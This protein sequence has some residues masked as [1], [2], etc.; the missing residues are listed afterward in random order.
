MI[1]RAQRYLCDED[2]IVTLRKYSL[3]IFESFLI[4]LY[5]LDLYQ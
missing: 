2:L 5:I 3:M 1:D 4:Q